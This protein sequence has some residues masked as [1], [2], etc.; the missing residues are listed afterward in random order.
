M[1]RG[2]PVFSCH[3]KGRWER[4][5]GAKLLLLE[6]PAEGVRSARKQVGHTCAQQGPGASQS[7][8]LEHLLQLFLLFLGTFTCQLGSPGATPGLPHP[9]GIH[10]PSLSQGWGTVQS[11]QQRKLRLERRSKDSPESSV[12]LGYL[13]LLSPHPS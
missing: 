13:H 11:P 12:L 10:S 7:E 3:Q 8:A 9:L 4:Q 2:T 5:I 6:K 1:G